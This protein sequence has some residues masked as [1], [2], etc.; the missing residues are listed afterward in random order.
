[1]GKEMLMVILFVGWI[2]SGIISAQIV[3]RKIPLVN[4]RSFIKRVGGGPLILLFAWLLLKIKNRYL[5][6]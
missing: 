4:E 1:M 2:I 5:G 3:S 6:A